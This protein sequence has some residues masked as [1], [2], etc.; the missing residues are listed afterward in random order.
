MASPEIISAKEESNENSFV[1]FLVG[2]LR[3][4][5]REQTATVK[6]EH[7]ANIVVRG[8]QESGDYWAGCQDLPLFVVE[9]FLPPA[10]VSVAEEASLAETAVRSAG[11]GAWTFFQVMPSIVR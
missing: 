1:C 8:T 5:G 11:E 3:V 4:S 7:A 10:A 9:N 6:V 2:L